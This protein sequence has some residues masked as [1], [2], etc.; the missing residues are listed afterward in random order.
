MPRKYL[1]SWDKTHKVWVKTIDGK[2]HYFESAPR[3][4]DLDAYNKSLLAYHKLIGF[5]TSKP[6]IP[7]L[8]T[9][10]SKRST[11]GTYTYPKSSI[12]GLAERYFEHQRRRTTAQKIQPNTLS[13]KSWA[14][15]HF[16]DKFISKKGLQPDSNTLL[17]EQRIAGYNTY[18][19]RLYAT[20]QISFFTGKTLFNSAKAFIYWCWM[21]R[22][23]DDLPRN[24]KDPDLEWQQPTKLSDQIRFRNIQ[25]FSIEELHL[26]MGACYYSPVWSDLPLYILL[27]LNCGFTP[28]DIATLQWE[29][30]SEE[31]DG[32]FYISR[33]RKKTGVLGKWVLWEK[34][35]KLFTYV[36]G[37][38]QNQTG[39]IFSTQQGFPL[40]R[41]N[42]PDNYKFDGYNQ[43]RQVSDTAISKRFY[44]L[45]RRAL[46]EQTEYLSFKYL[47]KTGASMI[48]N[49]DI[50]NSDR[51]AQT[52]LCH[53]AGTTSARHYIEEDFATLFATL[54][55]LGK[56]LGFDGDTD[57]L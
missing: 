48:R 44:A 34:T 30:I 37:H 46:P 33:H 15:E 23:I 27:A 55:Q 57:D 20:D 3:K 26:I 56:T 50:N 32:R 22:H 45:V 6:N 4:A 14:L 24:L 54:L 52:Y 49:M 9:A 8:K 13:S 5:T 17:N 1:L 29:H 35:A 2:K 43:I 19:R 40:S 38:K 16:V 18:L 39:T 7:D 41:R 11:S 47:R 36:C 42:N 12:V 28:I 10:I 51:I 25:T 21:R 53:K 31:T